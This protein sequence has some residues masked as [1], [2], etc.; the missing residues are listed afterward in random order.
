M[1]AQLD[2]YWVKLFTDPLVVVNPEGVRYIQPQRTNN[3][4][5]R[6]FRGEKQ[7]G[8]KKSGSTLAVIDKNQ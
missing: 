8:R 2:K 1:I 5:E 7:R 6:F 4:L 3:I